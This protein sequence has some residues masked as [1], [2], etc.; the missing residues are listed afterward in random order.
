MQMNEKLNP[1]DIKEPIDGFDE[2]AAAE[3]PESPEEIAE[4]AEPTDG[5]VEDPVEKKRRE[6]RERQKKS[7]AGKAAAADAKAWHPCS[8]EIPGKKETMEILERVEDS[9]VRDVVYE[10]ALL[11]SDRLGI[12]CNR[13]YLKYGL[14]HH[15]ACRAAKKHLPLGVGR[16]FDICWEITDGKKSAVIIL[17]ES[18]GAYF[19]G[20]RPNFLPAVG[21]PVRFLIDGSK[22]LYVERILSND[23]S[24]S[25]RERIIRD[26]ISKTQKPAPVPTAAEEKAEP[27]PE[28]NPETQHAPY[29]D[30]AY[31][32]GLRRGLDRV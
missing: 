12:P 24:V 17:I 28:V 8:T 13:H 18:N 15:L 32:A 2:I 29:V 21:M 14:Q 10:Q 6:W 3:L 30:P 7:R 11:A 9:H 22:A 5:P 25:E 4:P 16:I 20:E 1:Q 26:H 27:K 31:I 19:V 23:E